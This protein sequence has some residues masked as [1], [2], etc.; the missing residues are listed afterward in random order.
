VCGGLVGDSA[1]CVCRTTPWL[2]FVDGVAMLFCNGSHPASA[3]RAAVT[4][5]GRSPTF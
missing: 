4:T 1:S 5:S 3:S 2:L